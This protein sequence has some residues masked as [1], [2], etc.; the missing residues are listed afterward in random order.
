MSARIGKPITAGLLAATVDLLWRQWRAIGGAAAGGPARAQVDLEVLCLASLTLEPHE[1]RL[2][3]A[4]ADWIRLGSTLVSVQRL[5]NLSA[6]FP[7]GAERLPELGRV[8]IDEAKDAR[9]RSLDH[10]P[11]RRAARA[12][13]PVKSRT[14]GPSLVSGPALVLRLRSA[15]GIGVKADLIAYVLGIPIRATVSGAAAARRRRS[16][17]ASQRSFA[18]SR[19]S[20]PPAFCARGRAQ[21]PRSTGLI[22]MAGIRFSAELSG[23]PTGA[24]GTN[25][26]ALPVA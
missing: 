1:P 26:S 18:R 9:W 3:D 16:A 12:R 7:R 25:E 22:A 20:T 17:T 8:A 2:W 14:A 11:A 24:I 15:F 19:I 5:T 4:M 10:S 23:S 21:V 6:S 13:K